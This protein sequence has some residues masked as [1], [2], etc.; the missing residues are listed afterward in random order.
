MQRSGAEARAEFGLRRRHLAALAGNAG[1]PYAGDAAAVRSGRLP[2]RI[3]L[4]Q[5]PRLWSCRGAS[6]NCAGRCVPGAAGGGSWSPSPCR[7]ARPAAV[8]AASSIDENREL[9]QPRGKQRRQRYG[10]QA[11]LRKSHS[12]LRRIRRGAVRSSPAPIKTEKVAK[13]QPDMVKIRFA[14]GNCCKNIASMDNGLAVRGRSQAR[15]EDI[16]VGRDHVAFAHAMRLLDRAGKHDLAV[17][18]CPRLPRRGRPVDAD[19]ETA[20]AHLDAAM[21]PLIGLS[22]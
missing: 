13:F 7:R 21:T 8:P 5:R 22:G 14:S 3:R 19:L 2:A 4:R 10:Q 1:V 18:P 17:F 9:E 11:G 16:A 20:A 12:N 15:H 6:G